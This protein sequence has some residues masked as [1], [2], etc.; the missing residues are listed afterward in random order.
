MRRD[1]FGLIFLSLF[2]VASIL[3]AV[4]TARADV[5]PAGPTVQV[6]I[7]NYKF[8]SETVTIKAG[9][10]VTWTNKDEIPHTVASTDKTFKGS[11]GLDTGDSYSYTFDKPGTYKY[12]CTLHPFMTGTIVVTAK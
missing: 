2:M 1:V 7:F 5:A 6:S 9:T 10:T 3:G 8:D 4:R 12:Y 11:A